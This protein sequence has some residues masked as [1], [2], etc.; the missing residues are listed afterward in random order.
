MVASDVHGKNHHVDGCF[1]D[2]VEV[3]ENAGG[4]WAH[5][6]VLDGERP[7]LFRATSGAWG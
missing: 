6:R 3:F 4:G 5:P 1:G 2:H 7:D